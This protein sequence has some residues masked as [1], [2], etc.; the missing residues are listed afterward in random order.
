MFSEP[1][2]S[3]AIEPTMKQVWFNAFTALLTRLAPEQ[4]IEE[5][6][7]ALGLCNEHWRDPEWAW[8]KVYKHTCPVGTQFENDPA[9]PP[10][11]A[12]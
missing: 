2:S 7:R 10:N 5:A 11:N 6:D 9:L 1:G 3:P 4:A 12:R 8:T